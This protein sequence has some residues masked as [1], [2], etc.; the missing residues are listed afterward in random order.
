MKDLSHEIKMPIV[1]N[2]LY[3]VD[4]LLV[5]LGFHKAYPKYEPYN[6]VEQAWKET[7]EQLEKAIEAYGNDRKQK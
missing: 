1:T 6:Y 7:G 2:I 3:S 5:V 4:R